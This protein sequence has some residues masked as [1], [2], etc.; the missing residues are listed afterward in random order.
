M[1]LT[2][3]DKIGK[4][5][6]LERLS[7]LIYLK[8]PSTIL[9]WGDDAAVLEP[10]KGKQ[11]LI[12]T[13]LLLEGVHF[14]LRYVPL[15]HLGYKAVVA[16][17]SNLL[18]MN[19]DP[20]QIL[21]SLAVSSKFSVE[22]IEELYR[23]IALACEKYKIDLVGGDLSTSIQGLQMTITA[24]GEIA[25]EQLVRRNGAQINDLIV[26]TGD[27]GAA[28]MGLQIL[29]RE[30]KIFLENPNI[31]PDFSGAEY[32]VERQLKPEARKDVIDFLSKNEISPSSMID[33]SCSLVDA[34]FH[35]AKASHCGVQVYEKNLPIDQ[36]TYSWAEEF[37]IHPNTAILH[38]GEDYELLFTIHP[39][40]YEKIKNHPDFTVIG[41]IVEQNRGNHLVL[42]DDSLSVLKNSFIES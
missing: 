16:G 29:E 14:D 36:Q 27:L 4:N 34:L 2:P 10:A 11:L 12:S 38:G 33:L 23:G 41:H 1:D 24:L 32:V 13:D 5:G 28:Y 9:G 6:L 20:K 8:D 35:V 39:K 26:V 21:L 3:L 18:A 19:G 40:D 25:S 37:R 31:Q 42:K 15:R 7:H 22:A 17:I 30:K